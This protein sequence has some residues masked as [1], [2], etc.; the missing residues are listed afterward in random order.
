MVNTN[1][2]GKTT[3][4]LTEEDSSSISICISISRSKFSS[5]TRVGWLLTGLTK[6]LL[7]LYYIDLP[8]LMDKIW[9]SISRNVNDWIWNRM[10]IPDQILI[11]V[12]GTLSGITRQTKSKERKLCCL[13]KIDGE[14]GMVN[15]DIFVMSKH[16]LSIYK[17]I[18]EY[19]RK[20][21]LYICD[22]DVMINILS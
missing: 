18:H 13:E 6:H 3:Q 19:F 2:W 11:Q 22:E 1:G 4:W 5:G 15:I 10:G 16:I 14:M 8:K 17:I 21:W 20:Y 12:Y 7:N 9:K